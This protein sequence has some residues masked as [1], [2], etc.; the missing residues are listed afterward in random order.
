MIWCDDIPRT[1]SHLAK[2]YSNNGKDQVDGFIQSNARDYRVRGPMNTGF[3]YMQ[4]KPSVIRMYDS[5]CQTYLDDPYGDDQRM[6]WRF[7]CNRGNAAI[8]GDGYSVTK[9]KDGTERQQCEWDNGSVRIV[10][11][12]IRQF[13]N[14]RTDPN[15]RL[16]SEVPDGYF[17]QLCKQHKI[18]IWH[19]NYMKG[20]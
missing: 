10:Y 4:S 6:F 3:Y 13:P 17:R 16:L 9:L 19:A 2:T 11:L 1:I 7:A 14:G 5:F 15:G 20:E 12:P 8:D 18:A